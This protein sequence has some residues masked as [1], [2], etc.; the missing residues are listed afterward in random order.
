MKLNLISG[1]KKWFAVLWAGLSLTGV[2]SADEGKELNIYYARHY[3]V[4]EE[5]NRLFQEKTGITVK[6]VRGS[7]DQLIERLR[8][9]GE[10]SPAD[11]LIMVDAARMQRAKE[12]GLL[13]PVT[14]E[15]LN[16]V[17]PEYLQDKDGYIHPYSLRAR[18]ILVSKDRVKPGEIKNYADLA[19]PKWKG[20]LLIR[21]AN[22]PYNQSLLASIIAAEGEAA[23][24]EWAAG[25]VANMARQPQGGDRDQIKEVAKGLADVCVSNSY[26][27]GMLVNS[28]D[29]KERELASK[30]TLIFPN[31]EGRGVH[32]N[33]GSAGITR[34]AKNVENA[35]AYLEFLV[36]P[37][38]QKLLANGSYEYPISLQLDLSP[39]HQSWGEFKVDGETFPKLGENQLKAIEIF[40]EVGWK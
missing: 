16:E 3:Q 25:V 22:N 2:L 15:V 23:A 6:L 12:Q 33:V 21:N 30:V 4:D 14:M 36:S 10:N 38:V 31:Q 34:H 39:L 8:A 17:V 18:V 29:E 11:M 13:Q 7:P 20:R 35:K 40:D 26:Y 19:D 9:E 32:A 37:E 24:R 5:I 27:Y 28:S 1:S